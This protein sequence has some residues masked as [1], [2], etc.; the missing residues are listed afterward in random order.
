MRRYAQVA[1][2]GI[3]RQHD[4]ERGWL[5]LAPDQLTRVD[6]GFMSTFPQLSTSKKMHGLMRSRESVAQNDW[7]GDALQEALLNPL[8]FTCRHESR[9]PDTR[10]G[11]GRTNA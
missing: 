8:I 3:G 5:A 10:I 6:T 9:A 1:H 4:G 11:C 7:S 2:A